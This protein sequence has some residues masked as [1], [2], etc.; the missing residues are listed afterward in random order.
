MQAVPKLDR[1]CLRQ[2]VDDDIFFLA[3]SLVGIHLEQDKNCHMWGA[4]RDYPPRSEKEALHILFNQWRAKKNGNHQISVSSE[5][6]ELKRLSLP[7]GCP[8]R[9]P[10]RFQPAR[11]YHILV[12]CCSRGI[13]ITLSRVPQCRSASKRCPLNSTIWVRTPYRRR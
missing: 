10:W 2:P 13:F 12:L 1:V 3:F 9:S 4:E 8:I 6:H 5:Y 7:F 11:S